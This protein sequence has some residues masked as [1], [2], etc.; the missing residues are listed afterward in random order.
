MERKPRCPSKMEGRLQCDR[1]VGHAGRCRV[2]GFASWDD[3][4]RTTAP[5]PTP[6]TGE[7]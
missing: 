4:T 1:G 7:G 6:A 5:A 2:S 3:P